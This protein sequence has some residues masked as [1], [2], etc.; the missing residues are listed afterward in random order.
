M[1]DFLKK[2]PA[3]FHSIWME[4]N[5]YNSWKHF[6]IVWW[7]ALSFKLK[8]SLGGGGGGKKGK[9]LAWGQWVHTHKVRGNSFWFMAFAPTVFKESF[10]IKRNCTYSLIFPSIPLRSI[11]LFLIYIY[12]TPLH[13]GF[14]G[15]KRTFLRSW[16]CQNLQFFE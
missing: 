12:F 7:R 8:C 11:K 13:S 2:S 15:P 9:Q 5:S 1:G 4:W 6:Q 14:F 3:Y 16:Q 10:Q